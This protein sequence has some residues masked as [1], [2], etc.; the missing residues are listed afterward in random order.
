MVKTFENVEYERITLTVDSQG[1]VLT[2]DT[3]YTKAGHKEVFGIQM[4]TTDEQA[5]PG[6]TLQLSIDNREV[7]NNDFEVRL[8]HAGYDCPVNERAFNYI[9][10]KI[11]KS[12]V[13]IRL[14][15]AGNAA[16]YPY[17]INIYLMVNST[18]L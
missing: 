14:T 17:T 10:R 13:E 18:T 4:T 11:D 12:N 5:L 16:A 3:Y 9:N 8:I 7:F 6:T 15:D 2:P 1:Q